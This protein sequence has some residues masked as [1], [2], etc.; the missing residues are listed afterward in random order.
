M[1]TG[2]LDLPPLTRFSEACAVV[3]AYLRKAIPLASW[4]VSRF[5][6]ERQVYAEG[7]E[8]AAQADVLRRLGCSHAQGYLF[9]RPARPEE[10]DELAHCAR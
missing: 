1:A 7:V 8:R 4:S 2:A 9:G 5:D 10:I 3:V 6:G